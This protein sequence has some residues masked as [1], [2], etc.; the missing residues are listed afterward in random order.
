MYDFI[1]NFESFALIGESNLHPIG[2]NLVVHFPS[3]SN[4]V[5][6]FPH[7]RI[8]QLKALACE[9]GVD[10]PHEVRKAE[11]QYHLLCHECDKDCAGTCTW[12]IFKSQLN[13]Q[14][15]SFSKMQ[16]DLFQLEEQVQVPPRYQRCH[17]NYT[18]EHR[19]SI[20]EQ[21][22]IAHQISMT[23]YVL[24]INKWSVI[25]WMVQKLIFLILRITKLIAA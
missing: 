21:N 17:Q 19:M 4:F 12:Y 9:H 3:L 25:R 14:N 13:D 20:D 8:E 15:I 11:L 1:S 7:L 6:Y 22:A 24:K 10:F 2:P 18:S 23:L 5:Q 16:L